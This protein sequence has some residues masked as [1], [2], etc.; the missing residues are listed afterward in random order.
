MEDDVADPNDRLF[1]MARSGDAAS[2]GQ[3]IDAGVQVNLTNQNGDSL[4]M[5]AAYHGHAAAVQALIDRGADVN[6]PNDAGQTPL[7]GAVFKGDDDVVD[8][9]LAA[10][11]DPRAGHPT[12]IDAAQMFGRADYL[13][14][15]MRPLE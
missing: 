7:A 3:H 1:E 13:D 14:R 4:L 9:L 12:A 5:L 8:A 10:G 11:A 2:L 6:R 15:L